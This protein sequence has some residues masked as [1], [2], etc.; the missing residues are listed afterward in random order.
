[1][2]N[3]EKGKN[4][5]LDELKK[6]WGELNKHLEKKELIDKEAVSQ[7]IAR[8]QQNTRHSINKLAQFNKTSVI[9]GGS[10]ILLLIIG[11]FFIL[12]RFE[13]SAHALCSCYINGVFF[14]VTLI[15]GM[16]WDLKTYRWVK[17]TKVE[18][19]P[20]VTVIERINRFRIWM[21]YEIVALIIWFLPLMGIIY[22]TF[23]IY[24]EP[25]VAQIILLGGSVVL[26]AIIVDFIYIKFIRRSLQKIKKNLEE[27]Q[28][29]EKER[30]N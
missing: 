7:L 27:L 18:E 12:P 10:F 8:Y 23:G 19:M 5:E 20:V 28:E 15:G 21:N 29:L 25:L 14:S 26:S 17:Q 16:W 4:M 11:C 3:H 13:L 6:S 30:L 24:E 1:M 9:L 2:T 22:Y